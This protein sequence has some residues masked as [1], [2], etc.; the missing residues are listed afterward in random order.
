MNTK[1]LNTINNTLAAEA[2][3]AQAEAK[4]AADEAAIATAQP[5]TI[6][7]MINDIYDGKLLIITDNNDNIVGINCPAAVKGIS[8][9]QKIGSHMVMGESA[10]NM[11]EDEIALRQ[12]MKSYEGQNIQHMF[13]A[14]LLIK[15]AGLHPEY[16]ELIN[17]SYYFVINSL[18]KVIDENGNTI[19]D[20]SADI[21]GDIDG[22]LLTNILVDK[23]HLVAQENHYEDDD[24]DDYDEELP[25]DSYDRGY[26][27][28]YEA[29][30]QDGRDDC[31]ESS[32]FIDEYVS[33]S[34]KE[35]YYNGYQDGFDEGQAELEE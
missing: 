35:G 29:G 17:G 8:N 3:Q 15:N 13:Y 7:D 22:I 30:I 28:G 1:Q 21:T 25:G 33:E 20:V 27:D 23:L 11:H 34:Y 10:E 6:L 18:K 19:V 14:S 4:R 5:K 32:G 31:Y 2:A 24:Y 26:E 9:T 12:F 16:A